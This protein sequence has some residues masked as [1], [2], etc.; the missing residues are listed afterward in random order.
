MEKKEKEIHF[1]RKGCWQDV[2]AD[3]ATFDK[4]MNDSLVHWEQWAGLVARGRPESLVLVRLKPPRTTTRAPG[5]GAIR[6]V[7]WKPLADRLLKDRQ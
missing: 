7:D 4:L 5:P 1:G 6:K 2:E 3:E